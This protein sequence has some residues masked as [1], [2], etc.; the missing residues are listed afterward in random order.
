MSY[1]KKGQKVRK[2]WAVARAIVDGTVDAKVKALWANA[3]P[4]IVGVNTSVDPKTGKGRDPDTEQKKRS[5]MGKIVSAI[6]TQ[7]SM[8]TLSKGTVNDEEFEYSEEGLQEAIEYATELMQDKEPVD[9]EWHDDESVEK[10]LG[11]AA[12]GALA[13]WWLGGTL[14]DDAARMGSPTPAQQ[15]EFERQI[16]QSMRKKGKRMTK[17]SAMEKMQAFFQKDN[18]DT[19]V[20]KTPVKNAVQAEEE[21]LM[22]KL[23]FPPFAGARFDPT[24][25]RW[26]KPE[27]FAQTYQARGGKKRI[28]G[29][30]T[31]VGERSVSGHGKGRIRGE[32]AGAK[33]KGE[34]HVSAQRRKEGFKDAKRKK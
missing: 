26:V 6:E 20:R 11:S 4:G 13:G 17:E 25:H 18:T 12:M 15:R 14:R 32:G 27:N 29:T 3:Y 16:Q 24:A 30:G 2:P 19:Y 34:T 23:S 31:G 28:R 21:A 9:F 33:S 22:K 8:D 5:L 1:I 10:G 7:K